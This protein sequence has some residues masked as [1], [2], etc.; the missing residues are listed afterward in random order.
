MGNRHRHARVCRLEKAPRFWFGFPCKI[1]AA[2]VYRWVRLGYLTFL[3]AMFLLDAGRHFRISYPGLILGLIPAAYLF[4]FEL[5]QFIRFLGV[6]KAL[7][8]EFQQPI[9]RDVLNAIAL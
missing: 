5:S 1:I 2:H 6:K 7:G 4:R 3:V 8:V 9:S